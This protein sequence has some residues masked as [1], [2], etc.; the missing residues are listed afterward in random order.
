MT[1]Q[2]NALIF[3]HIFAARDAGDP[4]VA[5]GDRREPWDRRVPSIKA[6]EGG[7]SRRLNRPLRG[8]L[9]G[10]ANLPRAPF[11]RP[12]LRLKRPHSGAKTPP[13]EHVGKDQGFALGF[14][15]PPHSGLRTSRTGRERTSGSLFPGLQP[16][17]EVFGSTPK[18]AKPLLAGPRWRSLVEGREWAIRRPGPKNA[19]RGGN[20]L[21]F[22]GSRPRI[23]NSAAS[24]QRVPNAN[25][26]SWHSLGP[27]AFFGRRPPA[28][29]RL[30]SFRVQACAPYLFG[31][32]T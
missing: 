3:A 10:W 8:L 7:A 23:G 14:H 21:A 12:G 9:C 24:V 25:T 20:E 31:E 17:F 28:E 2:G 1:A 11:G 22:S 4:A 27:L 18:N 16:V 32:R 5:Q 29:A 19:T 15:I 13:R 6:P 30:C 26:R